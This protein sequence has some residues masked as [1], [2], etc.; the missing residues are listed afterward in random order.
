MSPIFYGWWI[1]LA[2]FTIG[3]YVSSILFFG[4][5][6]F[7]DPLVKEFG[8]SYTQVSFAASLRGLEMGIFAPLVGFLVDRF[9]S[10][11]LILSGVLCVGFGLILL[12]YTQSLLMF[13]GAFLLLGFGAGECTS[14][15]TM[16]AVG[17]WFKKNVGIAFGF[18]SAG[19]GASGL[20]IPIIVWLIDIMHWRMTLILLGL[21]MWIIG[22]PLSFV[23][24][25]KPETYG[26][27]PDG[28]IAQEANDRHEKQVERP[29]SFKDALKNKS[30]LFLNIAEVIRMMLVTGVVTHAMPYLNN[31]GLSRTTAGLVVAGIPLTS[32]IG[33]VGFGWLADH[34][35]KKGILFFSF[36]IM[37]VG[38]FAFCFPQQWG[39]IFFFLFTFPPAFG[40]SM[41]LRGA[42]LQEYFGRHIFGR[43]LGIIM[44]SASVGGI[45]GPTL[46]GFV[47]DH[48]GKYQ[49]AWY[50]FSGFIILTS[51]L[52]LQIK[53]ILYHE[54]TLKTGDQ[55]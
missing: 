51:F 11:K 46:A 22:I 28:L 48:T 27:L 45:V 7:I 15:V 37:G 31:I 24:R 21:G 18:L 47:F 36:L 6:A 12:S 17:N 10:R 5:T 13:Y 2:C 41:V 23:V 8:W 32:I 40:G 42:I 35:P 20:L 55:I 4:F 52:V 39:M 16:T 49:Y 33:R 3:L 43:M 38:M 44:G 14:I 25:D 1:V 9:G 26:Y 19:F 29:L 30:F 50:A 54:K 53:P 34:Y